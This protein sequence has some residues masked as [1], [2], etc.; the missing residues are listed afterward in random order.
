MHTTTFFFATK[1]HFIKVTESGRNSDLQ[2]EVECFS[3][4]TAPETPDNDLLSFSHKYQVAHSLRMRESSVIHESTIDLEAGKISFTLCG[5]GTCE[6]YGTILKVVDVC[7]GPDRR[8][9]LMDFPVTKFPVKSFCIGS[10]RENKYGVALTA[11]GQ[12]IAF[13][14][15][16]HWPGPVAFTYSPLD[17]QF[18]ASELLRLDTFWGVAFF[19]RRSNNGMFV[20]MVDFGRDAQ[21]G[22][23]HLVS[24]FRQRCMGVRFMVVDDPSSL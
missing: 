15:R 24:D 6:P 13:A 4:P 2:A 17:N 22:E 9:S 11:Q 20:D 14:L 7:L 3:I 12:T 10:T 19:A 21:K 8:V 1:T 5:L 16:Y 23:R 18:R